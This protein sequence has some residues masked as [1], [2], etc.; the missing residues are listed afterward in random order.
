MATIKEILDSA[1][2]ASGFGKHSAASL[3]Q[4]RG[5]NQLRVGSHAPSNRDM[6][7]LTFFTKPNLNLS[8][9]NVQHLSKLSYLA[10]G[11]R[12]LGAAIRCL[13]SPR[14]TNSSGAG[15]RGSLMAR[16]GGDFRSEII[17]DNLPFITPLTNLITELS[18]FPPIEAEIASSQEGLRKEVLRTVDSSPDDWGPLSISVSCRNIEGDP[19]KAMI[20]S[21]IY[22]MRA[23]AAGR[24]NPYPQCIV[25]HEIDYYTTC[26][27]LVLD[28]SGRFVRKC[29]QTGYLMPSSVDSGADFNFS[30]QTMVDNE[31][32]SIQFEGAGWFY[33][34]PIILYNFNTIVKMFNPM[35][36]DKSRDT[37]MHKIDH[38]YLSHF[39]GRKTYP[40][41]SDGYELLWY[42]TAEEAAE[43]SKLYGFEIPVGLGLGA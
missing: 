39:K 13:L 16:D 10:G 37:K 29:A 28:P 32:V 21:W 6:V 15:W 9:D 35:M 24:I 22:Y 11:P 40:Y 19:I 38:K 17:D 31:T 33:N 1:S 42:T 2:V 26:F 27:R 4:L 23:V 43:V 36:G 14:V 7:G 41:I 20:A 8:Y 3:E 25:E 30:Q 34:D 12:T 18:G 5:L